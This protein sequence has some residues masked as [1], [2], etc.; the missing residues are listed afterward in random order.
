[1]VWP[2]RAAIASIAL[3]ALCACDKTPEPAS[4]APTRAPETA[5]APA[6][7]A[8]AN[9]APRGPTDVGYDVPE[10]WQ[11]VDNPS[12]MRKATFRIPRAEGD[13]EDAEMSVTQAGGTV[14]QNIA[15]WSGQFEKGKEDKTARQERKIGDLKVTTVE[16]HG[17]FAGSGMPGAAPAGPKPSWALLGAIVE[18]EGQLTFFKLTGPEKT[19]NAA[20][21]SFDKFV[22][23]FRA[24]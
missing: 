16:V 22:E 18:T 9:A 17:T 24:K 23:S 12:P 2:T 15:R 4:S 11:K 10:T 20:K 8:A 7:S 1:M 21:P 3:L 6:P 14:E 13:T 5:P 19:I